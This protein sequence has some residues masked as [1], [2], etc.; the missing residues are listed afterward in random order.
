MPASTDYPLLD[1]FWTTILVFLWVAWITLLIGILIDVIRRHDIGGL[2]KAGWAA[3]VIFLPFV[4][5]IAYLVT[6]SR[7]MTER[8]SG[9]TMRR[10]QYDAYILGGGY[11]PV[12]RSYMPR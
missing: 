6:Q 7:G 5:A 12:D 3:F 4:G 11:D 9:V 1:I 2:G 8:S 10:S